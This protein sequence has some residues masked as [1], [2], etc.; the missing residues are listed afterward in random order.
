MLFCCVGFG[1]TPRPPL[2]LLTTPRP[3]HRPELSWIML[4][5]QGPL[6]GVASYYQSMFFP[7]RTWL[8]IAL[9]AAFTTSLIGVTALLRIRQKG[10]YVQG[11]SKTS[12]HLSHRSSS[13]R[14]TYVCR[15]GREFGLS[16]RRL[17]SGGEFRSHDASQSK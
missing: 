8:P 13:T 17:Q 11:K 3:L 12:A 2:L 15:R 16:A 14:N 6:F 10:C 7:V 1:T 4:V 5:L 9:H